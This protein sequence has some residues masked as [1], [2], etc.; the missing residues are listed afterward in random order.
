MTAMHRNPRPARPDSRMNGG[1]TSSTPEAPSLVKWRATPKLPTPKSRQA[2]RKKPVARAHFSRCSSS[3][4]PLDPELQHA[5]HGTR[6]L[7]TERDGRVR[8]ARLSAL[9][10]GCVSGSCTVNLFCLQYPHFNYIA[11]SE[12]G[13]KLPLRVNVLPVWPRNKTTHREVNLGGIIRSAGNCVLA[14]L[15][16]SSDIRAQHGHIICPSDAD[17]LAVLSDFE[18]DHRRP[19]IVIEHLD[20]R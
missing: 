6:G 5:A 9:S 3:L 18:C 11:N 17:P 12:R 13:S 4:M 10:F 7:Q 14:E 1:G 15:A 20:C 8:C 19:N 16:K 2:S